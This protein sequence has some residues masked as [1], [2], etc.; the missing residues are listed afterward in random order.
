MNSQYYKAMFAQVRSVHSANPN[1]TEV[2]FMNNS[3]HRIRSKPLAIALAIALVAALSFGAYALVTLLSPNE[4]AREVGRDDVAQAFENGKGT[5]IDET[6][7][8]EDYIFTL[9][10]MTAGEHLEPFYTGMDAGQTALV[11]AIRRTDGAPLD[12]MEGFAGRF[13]SG[14]FFSG[15]KPWQVSSTMFGAGGS[16]FDRDGVLYLVLEIGA[17]IEMFADHTVSYAIW[18]TSD[19]I[20]FAPGSDVLTMAEDGTISFAEGMT[21]ARAMFTLPLDPAKA[22]PEKV[23]Q[24]LK[25]LGMALQDGNWGYPDSPPVDEPKESTMSMEGRSSWMGERSD[26]ERRPI[27][28]E[29]ELRQHVEEFENNAFWEENQPEITR[30]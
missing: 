9:M 16:A 19:N 29:E 12:T 25:G 7:T 13:G 24:A 23:A 10:G 2:L 15:F 22:D 30:N 20:G 17:D 26:N 21:N 6:V 11:V 27:L 5:V 4:V 3:K 8:S 14:V 18:A 1:K 28:S